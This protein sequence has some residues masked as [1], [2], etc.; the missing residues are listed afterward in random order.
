MKTIPLSNSCPP[1]THTS[2]LILL[3]ATVKLRQTRDI[4]TCTQLPDNL[5][6][7]ADVGFITEA[8]RNAGKSHQLPLYKRS[9]WCPPIHLNN[10]RLPTSVFLELSA[11]RLGC[12]GSLVIFCLVPCSLGLRWKRSWGNAS[13]FFTEFTQLGLKDKTGE[14][15]RG[16]LN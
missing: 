8:L 13:I 15:M 6:L 14:L 1:G 2:F 7:Q 3:T 5:P 12:K 4:L 9:C 11:L 10:M 16:C